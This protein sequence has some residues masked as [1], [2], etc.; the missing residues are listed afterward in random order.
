VL[1]SKY[2][3]KIRQGIRMLYKEFVS[4]ID[5]FKQ[6]NSGNLWFFGTNEFELKI[7]DKVFVC[8]NNS[9]EDSYDIRIYLH[10]NNHSITVLSEKNVN[11]NSHLNFLYQGVWVEIIDKFIQKQLSYLNKEIEESLSYFELQL[12]IP[13]LFE[14]F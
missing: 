7:M 12:K 9:I 11:L 14:D 10:D 13:S 5:Y 4:A 3:K 1:K 6:K 8:V 2:Y